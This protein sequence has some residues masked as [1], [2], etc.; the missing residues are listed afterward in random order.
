[1]AVPTSSGTQMKGPCGRINVLRDK[2]G[3]DVT[4]MF[5]AQDGGDPTA[6]D[7]T[8]DT[9]L[10]AAEACHKA[11]MTFGLGLGTDVG[12]GG[13]CRRAVPCFW[14]RSGGRRRATSR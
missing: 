9:M 8:Y 2:A 1:M 11:N 14:R 5:P 3:I 10:K 7:W 13:L 4:A 12:F 6:D